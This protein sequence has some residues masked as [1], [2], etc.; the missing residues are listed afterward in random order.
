MWFKTR[1]VIS[2]PIKTNI[3]PIKERH[4]CGH[5]N[6]CVQRNC[7]GRGSRLASELGETCTQ[8]SC[9]HH[10]PEW[11]FIDGKCS[12]RAI[13]FSASTG[14]REGCRPEPSCST[15]RISHT[16]GCNRQSIPRRIFGIFFK[17]YFF[18]DFYFQLKKIFFSVRRAPKRVERRVCG[19]ASAINSAATTCWLHWRF[20][21]T[22][23]CGAQ[24][25]R[26]LLWRHTK[27]GHKFASKIRRAST[28][29]QAFTGEGTTTVAGKE[30][31]PVV[32]D[33][34]K[35]RFFVFLIE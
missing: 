1:K 22:H 16:G 3:F 15:T 12:T 18:K 33:P 14:H 17:F 26:A 27:I 19:P 35:H 28:H 9:C 5:T 2:A 7:C 10:W 31:I 21:A 6:L 32:A 30:V 24:T 20:R 11:E 34:V 23:Q 25:A 4:L 29:C 13:S 8:R